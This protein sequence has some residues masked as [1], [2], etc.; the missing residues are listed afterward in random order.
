VADILD[1]WDARGAAR[2]QPPGGNLPDLPDESIAGLTGGLR[3]LLAVLDRDPSE[4]I[5][6]CHTPTVAYS[7][8]S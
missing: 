1:I 2:R 4:R 7:P 3:D 6:V 5:A 8:L